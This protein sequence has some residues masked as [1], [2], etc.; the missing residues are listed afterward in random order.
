[1][2]SRSIFI[3][4]P[5]LAFV[6]VLACVCFAFGCASYRP[7][8]FPEAA[9]LE[10]AETKSN[11]PVRV[12]VAVLDEEQNKAIFGASLGNVGIQRSGSISRTTTRFPISFSHTLWT[13]MPFFLWRRL[14]GVTT[15][16]HLPQTKR[17][18]HTFHA[19]STQARPAWY[20]ELG[21]CLCES[22]PRC[23]GS[24]RHAYWTSEDQI[25]YFFPLAIRLKNSL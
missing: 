16:F 8:P 14:I 4:T 15:G 21:F 3:N 12:S 6:G 18:M 17:W 25:F 20:A 2:T 23:Q 19:Q 1:M 13:R 9:L 5:A 10:Q 11:G 24:G 7:Q 22:G